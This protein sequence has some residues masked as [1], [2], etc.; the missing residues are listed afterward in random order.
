[1]AF[2]SERE[3]LVCVCVAIPVLDWDR[4]WGPV[5]GRRWRD[6]EHG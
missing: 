1:M 4:L 6:A 3:L 2:M 5:R